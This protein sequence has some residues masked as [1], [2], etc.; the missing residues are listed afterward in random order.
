M[1]VWVCTI[2]ISPASRA[3]ALRKSSSGIPI[4]PMSQSGAASS[5]VSMHASETL[6]SN[7]GESC[8]PWARIL[9]FSFRRSICSPR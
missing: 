9:Q 4:L 2:A 5:T 7:S 6:S 3:S 1:V 8:I